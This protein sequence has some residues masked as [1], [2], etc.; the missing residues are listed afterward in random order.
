MGGANIA[1]L[2]LGVFTI[3][4]VILAS[5]LTKGYLAPIA[6]RGVV[7]LDLLGLSFCL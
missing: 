3:I 5:L 2:V 7:C 6:V 1:G 4:V